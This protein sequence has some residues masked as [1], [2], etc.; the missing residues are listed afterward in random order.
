MAGLIIVEKLLK[1][2]YFSMLK[3]KMIIMLN[4]GNATLYKSDYTAGMSNLGS[5]KGCMGHISV[6][7]RAAVVLTKGRM[8][9]PTL[10]CISLQTELS[11]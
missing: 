4:Y 9:S 10:L 1:T 7:T 3:K 6:V 8:L 5:H 11:N 2:C